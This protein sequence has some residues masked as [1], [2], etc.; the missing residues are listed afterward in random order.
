MIISELIKDLQNMQN[1]HG[2]IEVMCLLRSQLH[3]PFE[4]I[5]THL[6]I[7]RNTLEE[8]IEIEVI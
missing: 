2:D 7:H 3:L 4:I 5:D 1:T 6:S 8:Y